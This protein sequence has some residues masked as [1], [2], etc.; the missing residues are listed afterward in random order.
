MNLLAIFTQGFAQGHILN[1]RGKQPLQASQLK[2][3]RCPQVAHWRY[4]VGILPKVSPF[5]GL[6]K[7]FKVK[8]HDVIG[9]WTF[10]HALF[11]EPLVQLAEAKSK[12]RRIGSQQDTAGWRATIDIPLVYRCHLSDRSVNMVIPLYSLITFHMLNVTV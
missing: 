6:K 3:F 2:A 10:H 9:H 5:Q 4:H 1:F 11:T 8:L 7:G 12:A